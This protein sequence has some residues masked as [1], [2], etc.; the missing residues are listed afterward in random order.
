VTVPDSLPAPGIVPII[1]GNVPQRN[2]NFTGREDLLGQ[3]RQGV[4]S[5]V[6]AVLP[7]T[8][9]GMGGVGKTTVAIEYAHRYRTEYELVWWI[10]ADQPALVRSS[11]AALAEPLGLQSATAAGIETAAMAVLNALRRGQP[12]SHWLLIFDNAD[13]PE[14]LNEIIPRGP[15]DVLITSRNHR[16]Q[17]VIDAVPM[18]VF[19]RPESIEFLGKRVPKGLSEHDADRLAENLSR[20]HAGQSGRAGKVA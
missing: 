5:A 19:S 13:Q 1:W 3:L 17:S 18:D 2:K 14:D 15:G 12:F 20:R 8:L 16:W 11:L 10:P 7:H 4:S 9:Q 6:T